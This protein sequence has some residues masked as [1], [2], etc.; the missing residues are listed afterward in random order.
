LNPIYFEL[1]RTKSI[2][3]HSM[4]LIV[5]KTT[6]L[7]F[8]A[9][10]LGLFLILINTSCENKLIENIVVADKTIALTFD[11]GPDP[12][13]TDMILDVLK[14][15]DVKATFFLVGK[16]MKQNPLLTERIFEEGHCLANHTYS[17]TDL[18]GKSFKDVYISIL[19]TE[20]IIDSICGKTLKIFRPPWGHIT[21]EEKFN[22]KKFG[23]KIVLWDV[24][25]KDFKSNITVNQIITNVMAG[26]GDKKIV[27]FH[28]SDYQCKAS[29]KN[30]AL[31][32]P[33]II[34]LLKEMGYRFVTIDEMDNVGK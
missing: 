33:Q 18:K 7:S 30:T 27:L 25:S 12:V 16:K 23:F 19:Q 32:L 11:D 2:V 29:R 21:S 17:H 20:Q 9:Q 4:N 31:A 14:E 34:D 5:K 6:I 28:D 26:V 15:K 13:Y 3:Y 8:K 22:L 10:F 24:N 1:R